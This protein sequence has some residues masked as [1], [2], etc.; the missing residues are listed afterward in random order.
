M[1]YFA[2][3]PDLEVEKYTNYFLNDF[4]PSSDWN[5][6]KRY[7]QYFTKNFMDPIIRKLDFELQKKFN[8]PPVENFAIFR[9]NTE[10]AIHADGSH[11][12]RYASLNLP[13]KGF[14]STKMVFYEKTNDTVPKITDAYYFA[15]KDVRPVTELKGSNQWV[16]VDSS[17]PHNI[18]N[19]DPDN[20]R[21]TLCV[22]FYTNPTVT[23]LLNKMNGPA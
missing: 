7:I 16:L 14:E 1:N 13:L 20:P 12:I 2:H 3:I 21:Y 19:V 23:G 10:Q 15:E 11:K 6:Q 18:T 5:S 22:R 17:I 4:I 8:F 9:H